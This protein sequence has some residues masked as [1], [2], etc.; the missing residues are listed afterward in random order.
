MIQNNS[1]FY[2]KEYNRFLLSQI[3][4]PIKVIAIVA[5]IVW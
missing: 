3:P 2:L 5:V 1:T 4:L